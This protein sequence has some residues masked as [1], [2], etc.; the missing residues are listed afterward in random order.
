VTIAWLMTTV[1]LWVALGCGFVLARLN[2][3]LRGALLES[4][5]LLDH[6]LM[7]QVD[8]KVVIQSSLRSIALATTLSGDQMS[9]F[10]ASFVLLRVYRP[11]PTSSAQNGTVGHGHVGSSQNE[12]GDR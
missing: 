11:G 2:H 3:R 8:D 5:A 7:L 6:W 1:A 9:R 4:N 10:L 12:T